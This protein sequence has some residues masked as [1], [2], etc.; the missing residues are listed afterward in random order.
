MSCIAHACLVVKHWSISYGSFS[1]EM[2]VM[3]ATYKK[4]ITKRCKVCNV[5]VICLGM[6]VDL[7]TDI[8]ITTIPLHNECEL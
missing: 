5:S 7:N 8:N 3:K 1:K 4:C 6:N 2:H